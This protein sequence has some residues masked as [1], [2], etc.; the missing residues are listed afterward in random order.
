M[1]STKASITA[2]A[3]YVLATF[4]F[5]TLA[6]QAV[7]APMTTGDVIQDGAIFDNQDV[8]PPPRN[9]YRSRSLHRLSRGCGFHHDNLRHGLS[10]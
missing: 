6:G 5:S 3:G 2:R 7:S 4:F 8:V 9:G 1:Q 10:C